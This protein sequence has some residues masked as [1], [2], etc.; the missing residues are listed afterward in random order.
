MM[1]YNTEHI[2]RQDR[3]MEESRARELLTE[4]EY[5]V[6][7]MTDANGLPYGIPVN[8][9]FDSP[10]HAY[11]HCAP[12][13]KKL[14]AV[15]LH[16]DVSVCIVGHVNLLPSKFTTEYESVVLQGKA[17]IITDDTERRHAIELILHKY[18]PNDIERGWFYANKSLPRTA[19][20]RIDFTEFSGKNKKM[21][22]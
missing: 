11:I 17:H 10:D 7:S 22:G 19:I 13:G 21:H 15:A 14:R 9:V 5:V 4:A 8:M 2:R 12:E 16:P 20:I 1:K 3:V 18:S 6:M